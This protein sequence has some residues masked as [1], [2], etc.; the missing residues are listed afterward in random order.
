MRELINKILNGIM[1][2]DPNWQKLNPEVK[3]TPPTDPYKLMVDVRQCRKWIVNHDRFKIYPQFNEVSFGD[4]A[5]A[6]NILSYI[7]NS[8]TC[9]NLTHKHGAEE[10]TGVDRLTF[11]QPGEDILTWVPM[12]IDRRHFHSVP[13][14]YTYVEGT[15]HFV[16]IDN[17]SYDKRKVSVD[18]VLDMS[19]KNETLD[20]F[21]L[22][23]TIANENAPKPALSPRPETWMIPKWEN[24]NCF[25]LSALIGLAVSKFY[26]AQN[27]QLTEQKLRALK[28]PIPG[29]IKLG[30]QWHKSLV[31][32]D[33]E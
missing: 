29:W 22:K 30:N 21:S 6:Y 17:M 11:T 25:F 24:N 8:R 20:W 32:G 7:V 33:H 18:E 13:L 19:Q 27:P 3:D 26:E 9:G 31:D 4:S 23:V 28:V 14:V 2:D 15:P 12:G 5:S 1:R 10:F 16:R